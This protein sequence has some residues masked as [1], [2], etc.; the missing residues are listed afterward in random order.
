MFNSPKSEAAVV[1]VYIFGLDVVSSIALFLIFVM[2]MCRILCG[3]RVKTISETLVT[4]SLTR[5]NL[6][7]HF[8]LDTATT[9]LSHL[10][11]FYDTKPSLNTDRFPLVVSANMKTRY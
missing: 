6:L 2:T 11:E 5:I 9:T 4:T 1:L 7:F 3:I 8:K 10:L